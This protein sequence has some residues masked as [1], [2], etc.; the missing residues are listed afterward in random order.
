LNTQSRPYHQTTCEN[1]N[2]RTVEY[3]CHWSRRQ[4]LPWDLKCLNSNV[5]ALSQSGDLLWSL[6]TIP[7]L[8]LSMT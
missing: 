3:H 6:Y 5:N 1:S 4:S 7:G 8:V 2:A